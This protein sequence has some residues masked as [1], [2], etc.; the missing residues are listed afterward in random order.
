[1]SGPTIAGQCDK[2][3]GWESRC[4]CADI[5]AGRIGPFLALPEDVRSFIE[6]VTLH[7]QSSRSKT[8][9]QHDA[10]FQEAYRLYDKYDVEG[11]KRA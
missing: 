11:R 4:G 3:G 6:R 1:M 7:L 10:M 2:C 9:E 8:P 5:G